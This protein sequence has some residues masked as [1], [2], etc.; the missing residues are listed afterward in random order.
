MDLQ[1]LNTKDGAEKG[2]DLHLKHPVLGHYL[3]SGENC[4]ADGVWTGT[5]KATPVAVVVRGTESKT[6]R[7]RL[8]KIQREKVKRPDADDEETGLEFV[9]SLVVAFKGITMDGK[10]MEATPENK[11]M[12][13]EQSD[14]LVEQV[15]DFAKDRANFF[16]K[17]SSA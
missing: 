10:P 16:G 9:C 1:K 5:G 7:D 3:Y 15:I 14:A 8:K 12:F 11:R 13:F 17:T 6:V 2:A 4:D